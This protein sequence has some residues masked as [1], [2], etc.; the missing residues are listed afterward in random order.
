MRRTPS[1]F[2]EIGARVCEFPTNVLEADARADVNGLIVFD[3]IGQR[4]KAVVILRQANAS[5][6]IDVA[7]HAIGCAEIHALAGQAVGAGDRNLF[8]RAVKAT[9]IWSL[10]F[11]LMFVFAYWLAGVAIIDTLS[12]VPEVR[13][14][15]YEYLPWLMVMPMI[16]VWSYQFDGVY[17]GAT[18]T[19][20]M[21]N[22]M[23]ISLA[24]YAVALPFAVE[25]WGNHGLWATFTLFLGLRGLTMGTMLPKM[26]RSV[27]AEQSPDARPPTH[28]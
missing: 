25:T 13:Q 16:A 19:R 15:A 23:A 2:A 9:T 5:R 17:I 4:G 20:E 21:R 24:I 3:P 11:A 28:P 18:W 22:G 12:T 1:Q 6:H 10:I 26:T 14:T 27:G 8:R 7:D